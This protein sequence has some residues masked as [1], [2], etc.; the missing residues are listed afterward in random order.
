MASMSDSPCDPPLMPTIVGDVVVSHATAITEQYSVW[1]VMQDGEQS[2]D[3]SAQIAWATGGSRAMSLARG[4]LR[5]N[6]VGAIYF[7]EEDSRTWIKFSD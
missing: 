4:M 1:G 7:L 2:P 6:G 3:P 5:D